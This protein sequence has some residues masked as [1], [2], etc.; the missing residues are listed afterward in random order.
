ISSAQATL[1]GAHNLQIWLDYGFTTLRDAGEQ[2]LGYG[3]LALRQS[4]KMGLIEGPRMVSA[5][6]FIS[7]T[8]GK[9]NARPFSPDQALPPRRNLADTVD[10]VSARLLDTTSSTVPTG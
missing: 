7:V 4:I 6:N 1:W 2:A 8:G 9:W 5:G 3:Q 10:C